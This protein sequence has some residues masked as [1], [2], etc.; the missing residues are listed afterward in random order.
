MKFKTTV[1]VLIAG[2]TASL[3]AVANYTPSKAQIQSM[4]EAEAIRQG[5]PISLA[6]AVAQVESNFDPLARSHAGARGVMQI[7]PA[8]AEGDLG[9]SRYALYDAQTNI[10]AGIRFLKH[11]IKVYDGRVDIAL[12]HYNGGSA[13]NHHGE[14][15]VIPA[16]KRYV[17][18]VTRLA[19]HYSYLDRYN[20]KADKPRTYKPGTFKPKADKAGVMMAKSP[21]SSQPLDDFS[22]GGRL[23]NPH[24]EATISSE[25]YET[26]DDQRQKLV[27]KLQH[28][29]SH[30]LS[31]DITDD[32]QSW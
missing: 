22:P 32:Q 30:N 23:Y 31:R 26:L 29:I 20:P 7:M 6:M 18:E 14:L 5:V 16:T 19:E 4:I 27:G 9:V 3:F 13:V 15:R 28:L 17:R 8:T 12:S 2:L 25:W 24:K 11:L 1:I 21:A 10:E